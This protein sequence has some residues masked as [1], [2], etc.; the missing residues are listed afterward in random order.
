MLNY[1]RRDIANIYGVLIKRAKRNFDR[2][3]KGEA[4]MY[5]QASAEWMYNTNLF[6]YDN[7][8]E[9]LIK[10]ISS[11]S[12]SSAFIINSQSDRCV[13]LDSWCWDNRGLTQQYIRAMMAND[14]YFLVIMTDRNGSIGSSILS[15]MEAYDKAEI[16]TFYDSYNDIDE[17]KN[18]VEAICKFSPA[19]M[20]LHIAP[21]DVV[22]L[23]ACH[24][25]RGVIKYNINLTDHAFWLGSSFVDYNIEFRPYGMTVSLERRGLNPVQTLALP[26]YPIEPKSL[27]FE[28]LPDI[29]DDSIKVFTGG[30]LYKMLGKNDIF[31][32]I[33]QKIIE[34]SPKVYI[35]V[36]GFDKNKE[37]DEK[38]SF[39]EGKERVL[40]IGLRRDIDAVFEKCDIYL[41]TYPMMGGLMSQYAATH[42]K[43]IVAYHEKGDVMNEVEEMVNIFRN[44]FKSF[45]DFDEMIAYAYRLIND[46][47]FR[48]NE[49]MK[50]K[51]GMM[52]SEKFNDE[53]AHMIT[54][55]EAIKRW[56]KDDIDYN[57]FFYRYLELENSQ[58][59]AT[60]KLIRTLK[61]RSLSLI[62]S[63][64]FIVIYQG[65]KLVFDKLKRT[66][67]NLHKK[68]KYKIS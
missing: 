16:I 45:T 19:H 56:D 33:I 36:A 29:P 23:L 4:L 57:S 15:E 25:I 6:F 49:G 14:L 55:H 48:L 54:A 63:S 46:K 21:W 44:D 43:P 3:R 59:E 38:L 7:E 28:G 40:Q 24:A 58:F 47:V 8:A 26:F 20:F 39:I 31:F 60:K 11:D 53:F 13:L 61:W 52:T 18:I 67:N 27:E 41:G 62:K 68:L 9:Q 64:H 1:T 22:A 35:L 12:I 65:M 2:D 66:R 17:A 30:A 32:Q 50:I 51:A 37:F 34:I 5:L 42:A 10:D